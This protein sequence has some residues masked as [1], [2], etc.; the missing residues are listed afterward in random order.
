[1]ILSRKNYLRTHH[2][3]LQYTK[4]NTDEIAHYSLSLMLVVDVLNWIKKNQHDWFFK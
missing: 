2:I 4:W 1:M 3:M